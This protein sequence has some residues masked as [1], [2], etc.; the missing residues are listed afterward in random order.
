MKTIT[1]IHTNVL[2]GT[3]N[4]KLQKDVSVEIKNE[5][6]TRVGKF[7][8]NSNSKII[9]LNGK[10]LAPGLINLHCHLPSSG[11]LAKKKLGDQKK[12]VKFV[13]EN[14]IGR[15]IG[16]LIIK[17]NALQ[18]LRSG[19]TTIRTVG[20]VSTLDSAL[21]DKINDNKLVGPR[22]LVSN[23]AIGVKGGHMDG[24]VATS[25]DTISE[26][27]NKVK[28]LKKENVDVI[29]LMITGGVLDGKDVGHPAP[30]RMSQEMIKACCDEAHKLGLKVAAHVESKE[31]MNAAIK[32]GV[33]SIEH[34]ADFDKDL[35]SKFKKNNGAIVAT[36][37]PALPFMK[38]KPEIHGYGEVANINSKVVYDGIINSAKIALKNGINLGLGTDAG[39]TLTP[40][41]NFYK[42]LVLFEKCVG[43]SKNFALH[44]ATEVNAKIAGIDKITGTIEKGKSADFIILNANPLDDLNNLR[45]PS[46]IVIKGKIIK[47]PKVKHIKSIDNLIENIF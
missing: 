47:N 22:M 31:G 34:G 36:I 17:N 44:T 6:I 33:D 25:C 14:P 24:T 26:A 2:D 41:Y 15:Y 46:T 7:E 45:E 35:I 32:G 1:F 18:A 28:S 39:S 43:V 4:M 3:L 40:H 11:K 29:K 42:E 38:I 16:Y 13:S 8:P 30:L 37:S 19:V 27:I 9:D 23:T 20:G 10:F 5:K 12:L 21:R